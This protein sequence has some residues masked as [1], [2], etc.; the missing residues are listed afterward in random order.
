MIMGDNYDSLTI[1]GLVPG[2]WLRTIRAGK[3]GRL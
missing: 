1:S 3:V 2:V